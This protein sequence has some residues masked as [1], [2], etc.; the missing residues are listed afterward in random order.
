[1]TRD[2]SNSHP[3]DKTAGIVVFEMKQNATPTKLI[4][5]DYSNKVTITL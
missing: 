1:V 5:N 4:Y 3:G 2:L